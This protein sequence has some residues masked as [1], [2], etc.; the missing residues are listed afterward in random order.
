MGL[1]YEPRQQAPATQRT[2]AKGPNPADTAKTNSGDVLKLQQTGGNR[3][4]NEALRFSDADGD[5][6]LAVAATLENVQH[7]RL[8]YPKSYGEHFQHS[9][10]NVLQSIIYA[11]TDVDQGDG[12]AQARKV[13]QVRA[14]LQPILQRLIHADPL[15]GPQ[16]VQESIEAPLAK[17]EGRVQ[18]RGV[19]LRAGA[20]ADHEQAQW[21][22]P[23]EVEE[24]RAA[25]A[26]TK[27]CLDDMHELLQKEADKHGEKEPEHSSEKPAA[28]D[29]PAKKNK[30]DPQTVGDRNAAK[31]TQATV[32]TINRSNA[33]KFAKD[34]GKLVSEGASGRLLGLAVLNHAKA[35]LDM[36]DRALALRDPALRQQMWDDVRAIVDPS[37][38][39]WKKT[40][41]VLFI[42]NEVLF[43][44]E[45]AF[46]LGATIF[47]SVAA[48][49]AIVGNISFADFLKVASRTTAESGMAV[50]GGRITGLMNMVGTVRAA[51]SIAD[52]DLTLAERAAAIRDT[53]SNAVGAIRGH[54]ALYKLLYQSLEKKFG[55][56]VV[57]RLPKFLG[58]EILG[59]EMAGEL[60]G[61]IWIAW[62]EFEAGR[63][64]LENAPKAVGRLIDYDIARAFDVIRT[65]G[66][67]LGRQLRITM[68]LANTP[69][70][71]SEDDSPRAQGYREVL[72]DAQAE[73]RKRTAHAYNACTYD[74]GTNT[75]GHYA[76][77]RDAFRA[78][79]PDMVRRGLAPDALPEET[80]MAAMAVF[81]AIRQAWSTYQAVRIEGRK[82]QYADKPAL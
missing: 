56:H 10:L 8:D 53:L 9:G 25:C 68:T 12:R 16:Y 79:D 26:Q 76:H 60:T 61:I 50:S 58:K 52:P 30:A 55:K 31:L 72:G 67:G 13:A 20:E 74:G 65:E 15:A 37:K 66:S 59:P 54:Q 42:A 43:S 36:V 45:A 41:G 5:L 35:V 46:S 21:L 38:S 33:G 75:P 4:T 23:W 40:S 3:A 28:K 24:L 77:I 64:V 63:V 48:G 27:A 81:N 11:A 51:I 6:V 18:A 14:T 82:D 1:G 80:V 32:T 19:A 70:T 2:S 69:S 22:A 49:R 34:Y 71:L 57:E 17:L 29:E 78:V 62:L 73:L 7:G 39:F 47:T 44:I